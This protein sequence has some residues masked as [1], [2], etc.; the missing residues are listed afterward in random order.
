MLIPSARNSRRGGIDSRA[1]NIYPWPLVE[2]AGWFHEVAMISEGV[3]VGLKRVAVFLICALLLSP[4]PCLA[5]GAPTQ[6]LF[7]IE[8]S[9]NANFV[10]YEAQ[11]GPGGTLNGAEPVAAY[12]IMRAEDGRRESLNFLEVKLAYGFKTWSEA[13]G[14]GV[15][16]QLVSYPQKKLRVYRVNGSYRVETVINGRL[17]FLERIYVKSVNGGILPRVEYLELYGNDIRTGGSLYEK[18]V[19]Q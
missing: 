15:F 7:K 18:V 19:T 9:E 6:P 12:W 8:Q 5:K 1:E 16:V 14:D 2:G 11:L 4:C 10:Q 13:D 3:H 17:A